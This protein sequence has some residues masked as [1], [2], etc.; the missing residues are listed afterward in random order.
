[1]VSRPEP[2]HQ[3]TGNER[4]IWSDESSFTVFRTSGSVYVWE[5]PKDAYNPEH[6]V[7]QVKHGGGTVMV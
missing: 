7:P 1:M 2:G 5:T 6:I 3:T 4:M